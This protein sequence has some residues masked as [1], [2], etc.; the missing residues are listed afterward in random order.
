ML[1]V[2]TEFFG[3]VLTS[4]MMST[5]MSLQVA[6]IHSLGLTWIFCWKEMWFRQ[7]RR[8]SGLMG[9]RISLSIPG[10]SLKASSEVWKEDYPPGEGYTGNEADSSREDS[11]YLS[12]AI[13]FLPRTYG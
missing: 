6:F 11:V 10:I 8:F 5:R 2:V 1:S 13:L 7:K 4:L 3:E 12:Y 9:Y